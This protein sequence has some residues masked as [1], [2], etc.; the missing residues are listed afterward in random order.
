MKE[1]VGRS[2]LKNERKR[3]SDNFS[4]GKTTQL[5]FNFSSEGTFYMVYFDSYSSVLR[6][7]FVQKHSKMMLM[8]YATST[9]TNHTR[10]KAHTHPKVK[11]ITKEHKNL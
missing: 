11:Q 6:G 2:G 10:I 9:H 4:Y 1:N 7:V 3:R 8:D 5:K